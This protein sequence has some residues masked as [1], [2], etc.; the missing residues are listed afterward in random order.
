MLIKP[1][2]THKTIQG[3][4]STVHASIMFLPSFVAEQTDISFKEDILFNFMLLAPFF[5][6]EQSSRLL[7]LPMEALQRI[8]PL[9]YTLVSAYYSAETTERY[10][11]RNHFLSFCS[12]LF[13]ECREQFIQ[14]LSERMSSSGKIISQSLIYIK[15]N[16]STDISINDLSAG[17]G[18]TKKYFSALFKQETGKLPKTYINEL[19]IRLAQELLGLPCYSVTRIALEVGFN[20]IAYFHRQFRRQTGKTPLMYRRNLANKI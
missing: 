19:R 9:C 4:E 16:I 2:D 10:H 7:R 1:R 6:T 3:N 20:D 18:L 15:D 13:V 11:I 5:G 12:A 8:L 14:N 17:L